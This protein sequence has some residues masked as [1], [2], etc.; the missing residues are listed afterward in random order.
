MTVQRRGDGPTWR[1]DLLDPLHRLDRVAG[2][3]KTFMA[4]IAVNGLP[5]VPEMIRDGSD[6]LVTRTGI[7][8]TVGILTTVSGAAG[9]ESGSGDAGKHAGMMPANL[10][11]RNNRTGF[12]RGPVVTPQSYQA[13]IIRRPGL[14]AAIVDGQIPALCS[15]YPKTIRPFL[16]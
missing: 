10:M 7:F 14:S 5:T 3:S 11:C 2:R 1:H 4:S 9:G 13:E 15:S 16:M 6:C 12:Q 8:S